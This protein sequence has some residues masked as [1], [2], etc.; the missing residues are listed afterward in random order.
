MEAI[1]KDSSNPQVGGFRITLVVVDKTCRFWPFVH[2]EANLAP[3][4]S[5]STRDILLGE[6]EAGDYS[7]DVITTPNAADN[8]VSIHFQFIDK[9]L[10]FRRWDSGLPY[11]KVVP[12][13]AFGRA[14]EVLEEMYNMTMWQV[15]A[16]AG[17][18]TARRHAGRD[19]RWSV[20][21]PPA[22]QSLSSCR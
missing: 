16:T 18:R 11:A 2:V 20:P 14:A 5:S 21:A 13:V 4:H 22:R 15:A 10:V 9:A 7:Y 19:A 8:F 1:I 17:T 3:P 12:N 6:A